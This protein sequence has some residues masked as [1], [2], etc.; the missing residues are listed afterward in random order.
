M[1]QVLISLVTKIPLESELNKRNWQCTHTY[2]LL[3]KCPDVTGKEFFSEE[4]FLGVWYLQQSSV[5]T[6]DTCVKYNF[7]NLTENIYVNIS[8]NLIRNES[9]EFKKYS[10]SIYL[11]VSTK[12]TFKGSSIYVVLDVD[13]DNYLLLWKCE[14][15]YIFT[16]SIYFIF[17]RKRLPNKRVLD[18][19]HS[20]LTNGKIKKKLI[21][22]KIK[23]DNCTSNV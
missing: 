15:F 21:L 4:E 7:V 1:Y 14:H 9:F 23:H 6:K 18:Q 20:S 19:A 16:R 5:S 2:H 13:Y 22:Y 8:S 17:A 12:F 11:G 10:Q 3:P